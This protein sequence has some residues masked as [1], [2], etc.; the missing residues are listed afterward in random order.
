MITDERS[1]EAALKPGSKWAVALGLVGLSVGTALWFL[2]PRP[3]GHYI[4]GCVFVPIAAG[5]ALCCGVG[6]LVSWR[7]IRWPLRVLGILM[8]VAALSPLALIASAMLSGIMN[9]PDPR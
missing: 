1:R 6:I 5:G 8:I 7:R 9:W 4:H 2:V 3:L